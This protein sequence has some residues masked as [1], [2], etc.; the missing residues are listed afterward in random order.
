MIEQLPEWLPITTSQATMNVILLGVILSVSIFADTVARRTRVPRISILM[1]VGIAIA[2]IQQVLL[3]QRQGELL[4]GLSEPLIQ[5]ALVM[6]AFVLGSELKIDRLRRTGPLILIVS[7]FVIVGGGLLVG[8]GLLVLGYPLVVAVSLAAISVATDPAAVSESVRETRK[9][10]LLPKLLLGIV[11]IDDGW[12]ILVFGLSMATLGW[13]IGS[14]A[15]LALLHAIWELGGAILLGAAIGLPAA[16]LTG[17]LRPGE[18]TQIEAIALI[19]LLAGFSSSLGVSALLAS[20]VAGSLVANLSHHHT[21]SF[22]EI[23]HIEW[24]FLVFFFVLSGASI[25]LYQ[26]NDAILLTLAYITLRLG[27]RVLG[28]YLSTLVA[29]HRGNKLPRDIGL[30]LTPQ[31]GVAIGMALLAAERFPEFHDVILPVVVASTIIFEL[32]GPVLVR[33]VLR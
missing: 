21:R 26:A 13:V 2:V 24:P 27:G 6:V 28:G 19:L 4:G 22:R 20:M 9:T 7:L 18:P 16:W 5:L 32:V 3:G 17:R 10:G 12:G 23:E 14:D 33:R 1:L 8:A 29:D 25:D 15:E 30:A 31:A 11:A